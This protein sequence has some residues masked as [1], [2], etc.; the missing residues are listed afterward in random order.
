[1]A[2]W[3]TVYTSKDRIRTELIKNELILQGINAV[4]LDKIDGSYPVLGTVSIN[5]PEN[6]SD[7]AKNFIE[8]LNLDE[9][10]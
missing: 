7:T 1:M 5:V 3:I 8:A 10:P 4:I 2:N 6:Q 9:E